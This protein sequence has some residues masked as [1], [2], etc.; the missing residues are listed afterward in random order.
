MSP[1]YIELIDYLCMGISI[2]NGSYGTTHS[3]RR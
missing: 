1:Y 3:H 2:Y